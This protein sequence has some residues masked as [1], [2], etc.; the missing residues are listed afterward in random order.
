MYLFRITA[1]CRESNLWG[2]KIVSIVGEF[3]YPYAA[4]LMA[5]L[6]DYQDNSIKL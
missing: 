6:M 4:V 5:L 2:N 1:S 3:L